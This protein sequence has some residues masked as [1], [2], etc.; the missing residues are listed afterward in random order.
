MIYK[1]VK[2]D[3]K[4]YVNEK[5]FYVYHFRAGNKIGDHST[6]WAMKNVKFWLSKTG[7][8]ATITDI[9][10]P[11]GDKDKTICSFK[12]NGTIT[13]KAIM[14]Y[15]SLYS[16]SALNSYTTQNLFNNPIPGQSGCIIDGLYTENPQWGIYFVFETPV[17]L[18]KMSSMGHS[19]NYI[20]GE[21][22]ILASSD[23][24]VVDDDIL[25]LT[26]KLVGKGTNTLQTGL[27][28]EMDIGVVGWNS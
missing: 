25:T 14:K 6:H 24:P 19:T 11:N 21:Y 22:E 26:Y 10:Y 13:G 20:F 12:L 1:I 8:P 18:Y 9:T 16:S 7:E 2:K 17:R 23:K 3:N 15:K 28:F 5:K 4:M 27:D